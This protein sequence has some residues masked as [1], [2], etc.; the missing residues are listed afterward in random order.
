MPRPCRGKGGGGRRRRPE[1]GRD[2]WE[3]CAR[4]RR[5]DECAWLSSALALPA[6]AH[7]LMVAAVITGTGNVHCHMVSCSVDVIAGHMAPL[8]AVPERGQVRVRKC[9]SLAGARPEKH[10]CDA[11]LR[12]HEGW[13]GGRPGDGV[14]GGA[15][16]R[17]ERGWSHDG[18]RRFELA[19]RHEAGGSLRS[20][21]G[22][23]PPKPRGAPWLPREPLRSAGSCA[24]G[25]ASGRPTRPQRGTRGRSCAAAAMVSSRSDGTRGG[26]ASASPLRA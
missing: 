24:A 23:P 3:A 26:K 2:N 20:G 4:P 13:R 12:L 8:R 14:G 22:E 5:E 16:R 6:V 1:A 9:S 7:D 18:G 10:G 25:C 11:Q 21:G 17:R 19:K 15:E